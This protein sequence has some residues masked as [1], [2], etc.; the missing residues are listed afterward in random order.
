[1]LPDDYFY[2]MPREP[3]IFESLNFPDT[4]EGLLNFGKFFLAM[5]ESNMSGFTETITQV[6]FL[7]FEDDF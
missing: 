4:D 2:G 6:R 5:A 3:S 7:S 1:M